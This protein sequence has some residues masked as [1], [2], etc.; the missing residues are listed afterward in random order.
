MNRARSLIVVVALTGS[1]CATWEPLTEDPSVFISRE[2]P[3]SVVI[4]ERGQAAVRVRSPVI[5]ED[6]RIA[7]ERWGRQG[8]RVAIRPE[9]IEEVR[10]RDFHLGRTLVLLVPVSIAVFAAAFA[11]GGGF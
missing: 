9:S 3:S 2:R 6:A 5:D 4:R 7:G 11:A 1:G 10:V 8:V